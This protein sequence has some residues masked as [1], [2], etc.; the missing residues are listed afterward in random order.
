MRIQ[1]LALILASTL[2]FGSVALA[3]GQKIAVVNIQRVLAEAPQARSASQTLESEFGPRGKA[4]EAQKKEFEA[5]AQKFE[6]DQ[7]TMSEAERTKTSR[8]LRDA[9]LSYERRAKEFQEDVQ[10]RQ[11]EEL[12]KVQKTIVEAVRVYAK[13]QGFDIVLADGV[14][15]NSDAVD[16]TAQL[17]SSLTAKA[18]A[19]A[20]APAA[21]A[22]PKK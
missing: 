11:N 13:G 16:I 5:R 14:I 7:A 21:P 20:T 3:D 18:P 17:L 15:Y 6:R 12:Q 10:L 19:A 22:A 4:L 1:T 9:Q 2:G 8:E